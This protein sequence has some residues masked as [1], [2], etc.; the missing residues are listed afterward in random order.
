MSTFG[1]MKTRI[2]REMKRGD[3]SADATAV[4]VAVVS[5]IDRYKQ[6]RFT[7]NEFHDEVISASSSFTYVPI[8]RMSVVPAKID[9]IKVTIGTRDYPLYERAFSSI[10]AI[11]A[12]QWF[13]YPEWFAIQGEEIRL[14][15]PPNQDMAMKISGVK[16]L[17]EVSAGAADAATNAWMTE[18]EELVRCLAKSFL[19]RD[20]LRDFQKSEFFEMQAQ[21][22]AKELQRKAN[23]LAA[24]GRVRVPRLI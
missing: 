1:A 11:D 10:D 14:Y 9:T 24:A 4:K 13:G 18:G 21:R 8:S 2:A 17:S 5:A 6:H 23:N 7:F 20:E 15:P 22:A 19:F 12:G 16:E 3:L